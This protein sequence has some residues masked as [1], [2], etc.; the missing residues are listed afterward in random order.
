MPVLLGVIGLVLAAMFWIIRAHGTGK[1]LQEV[2]CDTKGVQRRA[3][4][5]LYDIVGTPLERVRDPRLA[6]CNAKVLP[7]SS[8]LSWPGRTAHLSADDGQSFRA[9]RAPSPR[10]SF[11]ADHRANSPGCALFCHSLLS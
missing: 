5:M 2:D 8:A 6:I 1:R 11:L 4:S 7:A 10:R 3:L 9:G